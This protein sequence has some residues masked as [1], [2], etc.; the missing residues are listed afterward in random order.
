MNFMV[1]KVA[2]LALKAR[3]RSA[4]RSD[5]GVKRRRGEAGVR[6]NVNQRAEPR[7]AGQRVGAAEPDCTS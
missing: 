2:A 6:S 7:R 3:P 4:E 5:A 1:R